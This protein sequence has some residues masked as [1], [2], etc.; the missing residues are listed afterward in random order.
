MISSRLKDRNRSRPRINPA[1]RIRCRAGVEDVTIHDLRRTFGSYL[2][3]SGVSLPIIGRALGHATPASTATYARLDLGPV[4]ATVERNAALMLGV[5]A[6]GADGTEERT[7]DATATAGPCSRSI[8]PT[9][10]FAI[11]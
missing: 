8:R 5:G 11:T 1:S 10:I 2:A 6:K 4:R 7:T 3:G 9:S